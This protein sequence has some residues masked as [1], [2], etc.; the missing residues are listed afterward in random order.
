ML[1]QR[2]RA[3]SATLPELHAQ[4][5]A[6]QAAAST[7]KITLDGSS[8]AIAAANLQTQVE[9]LAT[10]AGVTIGSTEA[11]AAE[12]RGAYRRIGLR[13]S[14]N[15]HYA[16]IVNLLGAVDKALPPLVLSNLQMHALM[17]SAA[18]MRSPGATGLSIGDASNARLDAAFEVYGFR[19]IEAPS[20]AQQ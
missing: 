6:L 20:T 16:A 1:V 3:S 15:G 4:L 9:E 8:D 2:L 11:I 12:S 18:A 10:S 5:A 17:R 19:S 14:V 13:L 7:R